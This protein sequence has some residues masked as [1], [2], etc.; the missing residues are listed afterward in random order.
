MA[1]RQST[2]PRVAARWNLQREQ[3]LS[4][5]DPGHLSPVTPVSWGHGS[6]LTRICPPSP[7]W[8]PPGPC[9]RGEMSPSRHRCS[10]QLA[11]ASH[12]SWSSPGSATKARGSCEGCAGPGDRQGTGLGQGTCPHPCPCCLPPIPVPWG[13][14]LWASP[15]P[16]R[17][18]V[19]PPG[20]ESFA[21]AGVR[22][23]SAPTPVWSSQTSRFPELPQFSC[24][25]A[26][27]SPELG[28]NWHCLVAPAVPTTPTPNT[29][30]TREVPEPHPHPAL[31]TE[32]FPAL[33]PAKDRTKPE[34]DQ[35]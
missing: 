6:A 34:R 18:G 2:F 26:R 1:S 32:P 23:P 24:V 9:E 14:H 15:F 13:D 29:G 11:A 27:L 16:G 28:G 19:W 7:A 35:R 4:H 33:L 22:V 12:H 8:W 10:P 25:W 5:R 21:G 3:G 31:P 17:F 30:S 20:T